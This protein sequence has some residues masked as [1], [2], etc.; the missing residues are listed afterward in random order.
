MRKKDSQ[1]CSLRI[2]LPIDWLPFVR[3]LLESSKKKLRDRRLAP[4]SS[5]RTFIKPK[6][7]MSPGIVTLLIIVILASLGSCSVSRNGGKYSVTDKSG[8][9]YQVL[10]MPDG[11]EWTTENIKVDLTES[12]CYDDLPSNCVRYGR[13]Y[14]W[15]TAMTVCNQLGEDWQLPSNHEWRN[16]AKQYGGVMDDSDDEGKGAYIAL[17]DGG[18][19]QFNALLNGGRNLDGTYKRIEAHGFYWTS[20]ESSDSTAWF[21]NFGKGRPAFNVQNDGEKQR[22]FAVR[23][24]KKDNAK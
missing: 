9:S 14:T 2:K 20:T 22:G 12:F 19:S 8:N 10:R 24:V 23:C 3:R 17:I 16:L 13:L 1:I 15:K 4:K 11:N 18:S 7:F 21:G 6:Y 5:N